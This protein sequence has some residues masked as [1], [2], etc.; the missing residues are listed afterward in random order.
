M[1]ADVKKTTKVP[2]LLADC[3]PLGMVGVAATKTLA[4]RR[5]IDGVW[6]AADIHVLVDLLYS[7]LGVPVYSGIEDLHYVAY[8]L[9]A[10]GVISDTG[11]AFPAEASEVYS[12]FAAGNMSMPRSCMSASCACGGRWAMAGERRPSA[13]AL[14]ARAAK[15]VRPSAHTTRFLRCQQSRFER[16]G[17]EGL[18]IGVRRALQQQI[19]CHEVEPQES[20]SI[21]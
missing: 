3:F 15:S 21:F 12:A 20:T 13:L 8:V 7:K 5:L 19:T 9:G 1:F 6:Q 11:H 2:V 10:R 16:H 17:H 18:Q 14:E 4:L